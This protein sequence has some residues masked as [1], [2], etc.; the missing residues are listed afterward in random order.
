MCVC[1]VCGCVWLCVVCGCVCRGVWPC[2]VCVTVN[3]VAVCGIAVMRGCGGGDR[4]FVVGVG[5]VSGMV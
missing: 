3:G 2:V 4:L 5:C 1:V